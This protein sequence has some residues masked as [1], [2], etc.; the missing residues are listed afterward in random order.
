ML[1]KAKELTNDQQKELRKKLER[2]IINFNKKIN[3]G[4]KVGTLQYNVML[5]E[6]TASKY[7]YLDHN[8]EQPYYRHIGSVIDTVDVNIQL[9]I[10]TAD[11]LE[12][13]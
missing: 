12:Q 11:K 3:N 10:K 8:G 4:K 1:E 5:K 7:Q 13:D 6:V 2:V 9:G